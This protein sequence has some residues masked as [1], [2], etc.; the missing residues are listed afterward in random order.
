MIGP[1]KGPIELRF[2]GNTLTNIFP[3]GVLTH[4]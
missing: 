2:E 4:F 3:G 1:V